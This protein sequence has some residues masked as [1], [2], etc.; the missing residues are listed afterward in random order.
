MDARNLKQQTALMKAASM[1]VPAMVALL[2]A[3]EANVFLQDSKGKTALDWARMA[4]SVEVVGMLEAAG[5]RALRKQV[6][7]RWV[8]GSEALMPPLP[9]ALLPAHAPRAFAHTCCPHPPPAPYP[10]GKGPPRPREHAFA[11]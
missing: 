5:A 11:P 2:L 3:A 9:P 10:S 6:R 1:G 7:G 8:P 4:R